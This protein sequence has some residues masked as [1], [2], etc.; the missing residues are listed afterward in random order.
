[1]KVHAVLKTYSTGTAYIEEIYS[2]KKKA[3]E[4]ID[5]YAEMDAACGWGVTKEV[6]GYGSDNVLLTTIKAPSGNPESTIR[7]HVVSKDVK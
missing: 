1:M 3:Q 4:W 5:D 7:F 2:S 6:T